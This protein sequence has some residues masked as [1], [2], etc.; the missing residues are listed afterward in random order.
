MRKEIV[1]CDHCGITQEKAGARWEQKITKVQLHCPSDGINGG[2][3]NP[4]LC[5]TCRDGL[6]DAINK[7]LA[8]DEVKS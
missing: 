1:T 6:Q 2:I 3:F 4:E 8:R 7:W 5:Y